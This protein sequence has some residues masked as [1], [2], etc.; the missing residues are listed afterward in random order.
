MRTLVPDL[1]ERLLLLAVV[2]VLAIAM[3]LVISGFVVQTFERASKMLSGTPVQG[4]HARTL[5]Q[6]ALMRENDPEFSG[7]GVRRGRLSDGA[8]EVS[9]PTFLARTS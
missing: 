3:A 7:P 6:D 4:L 1:V 8:P 9:R 2:V 5:D